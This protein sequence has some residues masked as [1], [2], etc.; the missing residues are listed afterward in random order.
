MIIMLNSD[1][2]ILEFLEFW[3]FL[4][5]LSVPN[6]TESLSQL[7]YLQLNPEWD[8]IPYVVHRRARMDRNNK[9]FS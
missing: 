6:L 2:R 4:K 8:G 3:R 7:S 5:S 9:P 1:H